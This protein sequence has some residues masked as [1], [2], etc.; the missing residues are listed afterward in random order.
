MSGQESSNTSQFLSLTPAVATSPS[1]THS[2][3][4]LS[5]AVLNGDFTYSADVLTDAQLRTGGAPNPWETAWLV[6]DYTDNDHFYYFALKTNGWELGKRDP[7]YAG[8]QRFLA[9]GSD[10]SFLLKTWYDVA[11][12]Q[13][14]ATISVSVDGQP[15]VTFADQERPYTSGRLG[16]YT[17]DARVFFDNVSGAVTDNFESYPRT[18][19]QDGSTL[20]TNW[21]APFLGYGAGGV[22]ALDL[23]PVSPAAVHVLPTSATPVDTISG[24][25][26]GDHLTGGAGPD[27]LDGK[28]GADT[29]AGGAGDDTYI[30]DNARDQ[31]IESPG[32]G[33]DVVRTALK[34]YALP[35]NVENLVLTGATGQSGVGNTLNN[36]MISNTSGATLNGGAGDDVLVSRGGADVLTGGAGNDVFQFAALPSSMVRITDFTPG[37]DVLDLRTLLAG[38][39]GP[40]PVVD[41]WVKF[42]PDGSG[43]TIVY[44]DPDG[45]QTAHSYVAVADLSGVSAPLTMQVDWV[46]L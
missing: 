33:I 21:F 41:G 24:T 8:G 28:G 19:L 26:K 22:T 29:M 13:V 38:Y 18:A 2:A 15:I 5:Q 6:W 23:P 14:G 44:V 45:P 34:T 46:F 11:V 27:L 32:G 4:V 9:T 35:A 42:G 17:E 12:T 1:V 37:H 43:G 30:V 36:L 3:L 10:T 31:V 39:S 20:G 7:A 40:S 16:I 25:A